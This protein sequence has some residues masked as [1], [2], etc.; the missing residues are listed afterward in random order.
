MGKVYTQLMT[1]SFDP[2]LRIQTVYRVSIEAT[3]AG[4]IRQ[5]STIFIT[6]YEESF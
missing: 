5:T 4:T 6:R 2:C 3:R 1:C